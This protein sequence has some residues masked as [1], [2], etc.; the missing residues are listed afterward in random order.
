MIQSFAY[1][2]P[3]EIAQAFE[4][5][6]QGSVP[7]AGGTDLIP[8]LKYEVRSPATLADITLLPQLKGIEQREDTLWIGAT[9]TLE[10]I[11]RHPLVTQHFPALAFAAKC[12]ASPQIRA[13]GT[14]GGNILQDRRCIYFNQSYSWRSSLDLCFKTGGIV[15]HQAPASPS[16]RAIYYSDVA[17]ALYALDA[18]VHLYTQE[19]LQTLTVA[20]L[21][22]E[23]A[24]R[25]GTTGQ[26]FPL[27][28]GFSI[29]IP[30]LPLG[31]GMVNRFVKQSVRQSIDFPTFNA[32]LSAQIGEE[33]LQV[34]LVVGAIR[35]YPVLL[36]ETARMIEEMGR[37]D[38]DL[39][40]VETAALV[41]IA[42]WGKPVQEAS[43]SVKTKRASYQGIKPLLETLSQAL[44]Q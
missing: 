16:C 9:E 40:A 21:C 2:K 37:A 3:R 23:H 13:V 27:V 1:Q 29:P 17:T 39:E 10:D 42:K 18:N 19:G 8:L 28:T 12:V 36:S 7:L 14:L 32:A 11:Q 38:F 24:L 6:Q 5:M 33:T 20:Q 26:K 30:S 34:R 25:N 31:Q 35:E 4:L 44:A 41:E 15:C 22:E 43:I